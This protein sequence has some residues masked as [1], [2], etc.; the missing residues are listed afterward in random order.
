MKLKVHGELARSS[1]FRLRADVD[2]DLEGVAAVVGAS[3]AGKST[4]LRIIAG[5]EPRAPV[6]VALDGE[7]WQSAAQSLAAHRRPVGTVFQ[8]S[9]LFGH[10]DARG[11]LTFAGH[12]KRRGTRLAFDEVVDFLDLEPLLAQYPRELSGGQRQRVALGRTLLSPAKLWLFDEPM[13]A[14][15]P[16]SRREIAPYLARL[17]RRHDVP[18]V[19][20]SH[21]LPEVLAM[22]DQVLVAAEGE[23]SRVDSVTEFSTSFVNPLLGDEAGAVVECRFRTFDTRYLLS[24]LQF[25][26]STLYVRGDLS[27]A[28][29]RILLHIPARDVSLATTRVQGLSILNRVDG[30]VDALED[31]DDSALARVRCGDGQ[32]LLARVTRRSVDELGLQAG[33]AVQALIK[34]VAVRTGAT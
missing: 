2:L 25:G 14:L 6:L 23:L 8:D 34:S 29:P 18:I 32:F 10:L 9:R 1:G 11:N 31:Q 16:A 13:S 24:E 26:E 7:P 12:V 30:V 28:G 19:Y 4:F 22:A 27:G 15:D 5:F 20:V 33:V 3:G 17:C 21:S